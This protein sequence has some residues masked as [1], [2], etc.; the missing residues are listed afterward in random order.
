MTKQTR[1]FP[2]LSQLR[3]PYPGTGL[4]PQF[5]EMMHQVRV[6]DVLEQSVPGK[7]TT[8]FQALLEQSCLLQQVVLRIQLETKPIAQHQ[9][10]H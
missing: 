8:V 7:K 6:S 10:H 2:H 4:V 5:R 1:R 3:V 9:E